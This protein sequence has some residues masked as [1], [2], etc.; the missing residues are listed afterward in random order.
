MSVEIRARIICDGCGD[1][2]HGLLQ[3]TTA[4]ELLSYWD[5]KEMAKKSHW[6]FD[7]QY[8]TTRHLCELCADG[9]HAATRDVK[10]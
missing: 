10:P 4:N 7:Y 9:K 2:I 6:M 8:G 5:A 3:T 1:S